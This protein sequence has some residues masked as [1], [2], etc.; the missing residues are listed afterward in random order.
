MENKMNIL[1]R[2]RGAGILII[3]ATCLLSA[4]GGGNSSGRS[5]DG[6]ASTTLAGLTLS[7]THLDQ[8]FDP[9]LFNYTAGGSFLLASTAITPVADTSSS[10]TVDGVAVISGSPS[11]P[12]NLN[13][14]N[15]TIV[16]TVTSGDGSAAQDYTL[17]V[18]RRDVAVFAQQAYIKASNAQIKDR[19]GVS[20]SLSGDTLAVG[21]QLEDSSDT[22][23]NGDESDNAAVS[24]GSVYV[25]TRSEGVWTQQACLKASNTQSEDRFGAAVSLSGDTLAVG[26]K[27][28]DSVATG[29]NGDDSDNSVVSSG[30]VYVF[31]R[32]GNDWTQQAY[33]KASNTQGEDRFGVSVSLSGDTLA[34]GSQLEDSS[35]TGVNG[36]E[37]DN[38]APSS[39][40]VYVFTR[41]DGDWTQQAYLKASNTQSEDRFGASVSLSGDTLAVGAQLED[42][43]AIGVNGDESDNLGL[44]AG[45][46]YVFTRTEG[47]W[48][49]QAY[50]KA[51]NTQIEDRFGAVV[52]LSGDTLAV[53]AQLEDSLDTGVNGDEL[54]NTAFSAGAV[55]VFVRSG[56]DWTQQAYLKASNTQI[57]DRFGVTVS[58]SGDS[59]AVGATLE[60]SAATG[61]N[62]TE[63]DNTAVSAGAV[64]L[65]TR[66]GEVWTQPAY[67]KASNTDGADELGVSVS[68]S[69]GS[70][71]VGSELEDST[72]TG[73]NGDDSS[74]FAPS[75]GAVY[76]FQ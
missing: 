10:I 65:F 69:D 29:V 3:L 51:S 16:V 48:T 42:S 24:S 23:V 61:V 18:T 68:V 64:Y 26:A 12:I 50:L 36:D 33:L 7:G 2:L 13:P 30:A 63:L 57:E 6:G 25:F 49:Q 59:L 66:S 45:A 1:D 43:L 53:G 8:I 31:T 58:L 55:Y 76:L 21:T 46:A 47:V 20:V 9:N 17:E 15:N 4:C 19:L 5:D 35:D 34:V 39:G 37:S 28:E 22:G 41:S 75:T 14:G 27:F 32:S 72:A 11:Q 54:D 62:N 44:S 73:V 52:S 67:L 71:A 74:N 38:A 60:D 70:V 56:S 40:A